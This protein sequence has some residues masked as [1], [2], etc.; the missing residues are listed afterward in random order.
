MA[1]LQACRNPGVF[2]SIMTPKE[3]AEEL[4]NKYYRQITYGGN[5]EE[6]NLDYVN[7]KECAIIAVEEIL[8]AMPS[9]RYFVFWQE[10]KQVLNAL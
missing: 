10:V 8:N 5:I 9:E 6:V 7:A 3:K 2:I 4:I 1:P